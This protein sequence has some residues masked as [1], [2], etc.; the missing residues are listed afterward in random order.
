VN[1]ANEGLLKQLRDTGTRTLAYANP[2]DKYWS[3]GTSPDTDVAK[4]GKW[5]GA[6]KLGILLMEVRTELKD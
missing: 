2:R 5:K 3:I 4:T 1:P 6:N